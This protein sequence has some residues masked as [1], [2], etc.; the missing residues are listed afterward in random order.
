MK[1]SSSSTWLLIGLWFI[2]ALIVGG[3]WW[4]ITAQTEVANDI[5]KKI[6]ENE[7]SVLDA[8]WEKAAN[9]IQQLIV[10]WEKTR[11]MW[12]LHTE[13][14]EM[15]E[16]TDA[17][18]EAEALIAAEEVGAIAALRKA[19]DRIITLPQRDRLDLENLF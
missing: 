1:R 19:R 17:L 7:A 8:N 10:T 4:I 16:I 11:R 15:D 12:A 13:H 5:A 3:S 9:E 14:M 6:E 18:V 2:A